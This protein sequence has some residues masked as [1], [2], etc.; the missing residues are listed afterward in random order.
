MECREN[1]RGMCIT[2][3]GNQKKVHGG[4]DISKFSR[5]SR[6]LGK[7]VDEDLGDERG[8]EDHV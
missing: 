7:K 1:R 8:G 2:V 5:M 3:Y 6:C 4:S